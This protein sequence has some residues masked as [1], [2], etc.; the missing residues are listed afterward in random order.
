MGCPRNDSGLV[1]DRVV[2]YVVMDY[3]E[4]RVLMLL[5][6]ELFLVLCILQD[7]CK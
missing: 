5:G 2:L 7:T 4:V 6:D 1:K 3:H